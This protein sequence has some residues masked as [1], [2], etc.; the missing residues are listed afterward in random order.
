MRSFTVL[1]RS[2]HELVCSACP[3]G[4]LRETV[5]S[6]W[7]RLETIRRSTFGLMP[8]RPQQSVDEHERI[9]ALIEAGASR[10]EIEHVAREHKLR[11]LRAFEARRADGSA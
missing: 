9:I 1:N 6:E 10:N 7:V 3:N 5:S 11:T 8:G 2:F 4:Y